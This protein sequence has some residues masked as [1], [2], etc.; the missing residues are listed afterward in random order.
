MTMSRNAKLKAEL[1][2]K[3]K[4]PMVSGRTGQPISL[5]EFAKSRLGR[6]ETDAV[7]ATARKMEREGWRMTERGSFRRVVRKG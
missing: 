7:T 2:L 3:G 5:K 1:V 6:G 4:R